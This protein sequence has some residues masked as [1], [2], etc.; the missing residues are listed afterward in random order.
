MDI[1]P[2]RLLFIASIGN[3]APYHNTRHSAGHLLLDALKPLLEVTLPNTGLYYETWQSPSLMNV[4]GPKLVRRLEQWATERANRLERIA[5]VA[6]TRAS[7]STPNI[8]TQTTYPTTLIILHDELS[9]AQGKVRVIRG[10]PETFS[11]RGHRGLVSICE[12]LR[13]KGLYPRSSSPNKSVSGPLA[14]LSILRVGLGIGRPASHDSG[15]VSDYVLKTVTDKE[16]KSY[17]AAAMPVAQ[18]IR[19]ELVRPAGKV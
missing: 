10:G 16:L 1:L 14:D 9:I 17:H 7:A 13:K 4:T 5:S 3:P 18:T 8:P 12:T 11:L 6:A 2:R 19:D 15:A